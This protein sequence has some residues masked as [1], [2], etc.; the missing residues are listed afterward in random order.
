VESNV[1]KRAKKVAMPPVKAVPIGTPRSSEPSG[2]PIITANLR[3]L[4]KA[5]NMPASGL[6]KLIGISPQAVSLWFGLQTAPT[7]RRLNQIAN[8]FGVTVEQLR[9]GPADDFVRNL[10]QLDMRLMNNPEGKPRLDRSAIIGCWQVP[11][12][13]VDGP[14]A[15]SDV[16]VLVV[17]DNGLEPDVRV[18]DYVFADIACHAVVVPGI[19]LLLIAG[20]PAWRRCHPLFADKVRVTD[21]VVSQ[22]IP[23]EDLS[24]LARAVRA[25]TRP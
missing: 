12:D 20:A 6:A 17:K 5:E 7:A 25:V 2:D 11:R 15:P 18:G 16:A 3:R 1:A 9:R 19:Y 8:I 21:R 14:A 24:V 13:V 10:N 23:A 22:D 4:M